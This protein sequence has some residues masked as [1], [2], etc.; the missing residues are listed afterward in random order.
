MMSFQFFK[1]N[2][3]AKAC[4]LF[5]VNSSFEWDDQV[6]VKPAMSN[7]SIRTQTM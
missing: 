3:K 5:L 1:K 6:V 4:K 7:K 2:K